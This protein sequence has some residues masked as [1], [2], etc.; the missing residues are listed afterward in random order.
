MG[1]T[2]DHRGKRHNTN[3]KKVLEWLHSHTIKHLKK[4]K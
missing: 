2:G 3:L 4:G 1:A